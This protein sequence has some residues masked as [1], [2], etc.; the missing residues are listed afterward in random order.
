[1]RKYIVIKTERGHRKLFVDEIHYCKAQ[2]VYTKVYLN[3]TDNPFVVPKLLKE[4]EELFT[5]YNFFR[6]NR[7]YLVN[8]DHCNEILSNGILELG[9]FTGEKLKI[10]R[11]RYKLLVEKF[12]AY[13]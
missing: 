12:Y 13:S 7:S 2:G 9:L 8:L 11:S 3:N 4:F 5:S 10:S 6:I 1:M